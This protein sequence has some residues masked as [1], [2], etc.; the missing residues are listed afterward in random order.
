MSIT[1]PLN[2][3]SNRQISS[4]RLLVNNSVAVSQ[5]PFSAAQQVY[6]Y[7]G[8]YWEADITLRPMNRDEAEYWISFLLK[9]NGQFGTFL[10]GDPNGKNPRGVASGTPMVYGANQTGNS[11]F[12][13]GWTPSTTN[14]LKAGDYIQLGSGATSRMYKVLNDVNSDSSGIAELD[15]YPSL[16]S[17]PADNSAVYTTNASSVF[18]LSAN[19]TAW[20]ITEA[21]VYGL[22]FG[23]REAL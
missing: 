15:I 22:T 11:L 8:Q 5:S 19:Q 7:T 20:D 23:A 10:L 9:L 21:Q 17:S 16:R 2:L 13:D 12:V 18:R 1:Y 3:P 14:I 4:V 6:R